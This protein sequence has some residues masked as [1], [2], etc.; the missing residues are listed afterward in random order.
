MIGKIVD[1]ERKYL[2][3]LEV[4]LNGY[5]PV[6]KE[7]TT[8]RDLRMLFPSQLEPLMMK[9]EELLSQLEARMELDHTSTKVGDIFVS[10]F[11]VSIILIMKAW[12]A[13]LPCGVYKLTLT[14]TRMH[15]PPTP[16][17]HTH[18]QSF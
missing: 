8:P 5:Q 14:H 4:V 6:I 7:V 18:S 12:I 1:A 17:P 11:N 15:P 2:R 10:L 9:H 16:P 13:S 3:H